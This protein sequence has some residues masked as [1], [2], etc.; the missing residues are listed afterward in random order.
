MYLSSPKQAVL[1]GRAIVRSLTLRSM[2]L[3][4]LAS[5]LATGAVAQ[6]ATPGNSADV[7]GSN[8]SRE[9]AT[10]SKTQSPAAVAVATSQ[11]DERYRIGPGDILDIRIF[12][13]PNLSRDAVRVEGN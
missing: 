7:A 10:N 2:L 4:A 5:V 3:L 11:P 8:A 12:N 6:V 9:T 1:D 13:R